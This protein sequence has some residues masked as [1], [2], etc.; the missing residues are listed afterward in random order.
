MIKRAGGI[1]WGGDDLLTL[2]TLYSCNICNTQLGQLV[3]LII[4]SK[5][6]RTN[7]MSILYRSTFRYQYKCGEST[8]QVFLN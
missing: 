5:T 8:K 7:G 6:T 1:G 4:L 3:T 2:T